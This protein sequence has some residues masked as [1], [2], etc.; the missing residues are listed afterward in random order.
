MSVTLYDNALLEKIK[1]VFNN[2]VISPPDMAFQ[3]SAE[4][5][6]GDVKVPLLSIYREN[7]TLNRDN[8]NM[9]RTRR[10][11]KTEYVNSE[12]SGVRMVKSLPIR[13]D[14]VLDVWAKE[15]EVVDKMVAELL[16]WL[17][18]N[19]MITI[20]IPNT[21]DMTQ[22]FK[23]TIE[24]MTDN[25]DVMS[26]EERGRIYRVSIPFYIDQ[27]QLYATEDLKTAKTLDIELDV[28]E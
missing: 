4:L 10:G 2:V 9:M 1:P 11:R 8:F 18:E 12:K 27:A 16:F 21:T 17:V 14:Y 7:Y 26:F 15:R 22:D 25:S 3:R 20:T 6:K 5:N 13:I 28:M 23:L 19:P 24:D